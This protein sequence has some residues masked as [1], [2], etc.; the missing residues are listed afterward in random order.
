MYVCMHG[1]LSIWWITCTR[2]EITVVLERTRL[3]VWPK[4]RA[5]VSLKRVFKLNVVYCS[6]TNKGRERMLLVYDCEFICMQSCF[7]LHLPAFANPLIALHVSPCSSLG[8]RAHLDSLDSAIVMATLE[9]HFSGHLCLFL[10]PLPPRHSENHVE[11]VCVFFLCVCSCIHE[12]I[13]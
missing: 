3:V 12:C 4:N 6:Q 13:P 11:F 1:W 7:P 5:C 10:A 9:L 8:L 2:M